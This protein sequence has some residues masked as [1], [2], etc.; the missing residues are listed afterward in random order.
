MKPNVRR[1]NGSTG[2][3]LAKN[4]SIHVPGETFCCCTETIRKVLKLRKCEARPHSISVVVRQM[5]DRVGKR[6]FAVTGVDRTKYS[7]MK[8]ARARGL[9]VKVDGFDRTCGLR[10]TARPPPGSKYFTSFGYFENREGDMSFW[11]MY[12][13][14][15]DRGA[16]SIHGRKS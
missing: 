16:F 14:V 9:S 3:F 15:C 2:C 8:H 12:I 7:S 13:N 11:Q 1:S 6:G 4:I 10:K 5:F